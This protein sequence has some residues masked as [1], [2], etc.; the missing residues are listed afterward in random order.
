MRSRDYV[1]LVAVG[2]LIGVFIAFSLGLHPVC[3]V[4]MFIFIV[5]VVVMMWDRLSSRAPGDGPLVRL[6]AIL[7]GDDDEDRARGGDDEVLDAVV[8]D[9]AGSAGSGPPPTEEHMVD[10]YRTVLRL[11]DDRARALYRAGYT[12][13]EGLEG[14]GVDVLM[15]VDGINPTVARKIVRS[16]EK[17][18]SDRA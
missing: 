1:L 7:G 18:F 3:G 11:D 4:A 8:L 6:P 14:V 13:L 5:A 16:V 12:R 10:I 15:K 17:I 2:G 9:D